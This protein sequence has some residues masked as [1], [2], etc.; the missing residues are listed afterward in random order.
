MRHRT[1]TKPVKLV[2]KP[3]TLK[4]KEQSWR[5]LNTQFQDTRLSNKQCSIGIKDQ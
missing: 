1:A 4:Q 3:Q 2:C 5:Y